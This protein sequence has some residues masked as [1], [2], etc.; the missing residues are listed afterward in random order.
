VLLAAGVVALAGL[1]YLPT[2]DY[3]F[4]SDDMTLIV[5]NQDLHASTPFGFFGQSYTHWRSTQGLSPHAY[6]RPLVI[7]SFWLDSRLWGMNPFGFH[8][9]NLLLNCV[10][11]ALVVLVLVQM[12]GSFWP[13]VLGGL[14]FVWHAAHVESVAFV[15]GRTDLMMALF[16][17]LAFLALLRFRRRPTAAQLALTLAPLAAALLCKEAAILFPALALFVLLPELGKPVQRRRGWLLSGAMGV[18]VAAYLVARAAVLTGPAPGWGEAGPGLRFMLAVNSFGRYA[19]MSLLPFERRVFFLDPV[20]L[21][22]FGWPTVVAAVA[23]AAA[24]WAAIRYRSTPVGIGSLWFLLFIMPACDLFPPGRSFLS[25]RMLYLPTVGTVLAVAALAASVRSRRKVI[26]V[27]ALLY[28]GAM[29]SF[30]VI[31]M[32]VGRAN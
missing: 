2:L 4:V 3:G 22:A 13:A 5:Q 10:V 16:V 1:L 28:A 19:L 20:A 27:L 21:G 14:A 18:V 32:P 24:V 29:G 26:G 6:Y 8:L 9:T 15:S 12:L 25:Q 23:L 31:S 17:L 7:S 30:A 11:G